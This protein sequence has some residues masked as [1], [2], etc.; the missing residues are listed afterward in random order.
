MTNPD[1]FHLLSDRLNARSATF[2]G[3]VNSSFPNSA[4]GASQLYIRVDETNGLLVFTIKYA[5]GSTVKVGAL[6][7]S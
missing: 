3:A 7:L 5:N 6:P 2:L 1:T 4:L